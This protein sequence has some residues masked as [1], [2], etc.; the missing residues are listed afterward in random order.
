MKHRFLM[1][2]AWVAATGVMVVSIAGC[3]K[4]ASNETAATPQTAVSADNSSNT[5]TPPADS[6]NVTGAGSQKGDGPH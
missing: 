4:P 2:C 3:N 5:M 6:A 1:K